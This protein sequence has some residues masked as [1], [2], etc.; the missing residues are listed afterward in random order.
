MELAEGG[1]L[2][3]DEIGD[4]TLETQVKLLRLLEEGTFE[5]VGGSQ[6]LAVK[7][8]IVAATN[9]N[10]EEM[11]ST[12]DFR[13]DLYYRLNAFP[14][15]LPPLRERKVDIPYLAEFFKTRMATHLNK[16]IDPLTIEVIEVLQ[17][18]HWPGNVRELEHTINRAIIVC[19]D[20]RIDVGD[21]G[22][23]SSSPP[24]FTGR[25]IVPLA[26]YERDYI[27]KVLKATNWK[28]K[29][30]HGAAALLGL[31]PAT[32]YGKMRKQ[33]IK[34]PGKDHISS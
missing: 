23:I 6:T 30:V 31:H 34:R 21:I 7:T 11:V 3:L 5:R 4:M 25:E 2:F 32:L 16:Q 1:T 29:G 26:E 20:S 28:V 33:G 12:G 24:V 27:L 15:Y 10:L 19:Q 9:R 13:E 22:L 17:A 14:M 8:R 18:Y